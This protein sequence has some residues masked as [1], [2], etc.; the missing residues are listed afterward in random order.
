MDIVPLRAIESSELNHEDI[1]IVDRT[2]EHVGERRL[3]MH[4]LKRYAAALLLGAMALAVGVPAY[5][6][7]VRPS[8]AVYHRHLVVFACQVLPYAVAAGIWLPARTPAAPRIAFG[9]STL[10]FVVACILYVPVYVKPSLVSGD[11]VGLAYIFV[12]LAT[13]AGILAI[14]LVAF[15]VEWWTG[16]TRRR[17][18]R[19]A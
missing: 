12:C 16:R 13:I 7:L 1:V 15:G 2:G 9:L 6:I 10:L 19:P 17:A 18:Q 4:Q 8:S 11:M 5:L 14:S 3:L